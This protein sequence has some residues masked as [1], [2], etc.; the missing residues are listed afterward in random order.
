MQLP[1]YQVDAFTDHAL[2]GNPAAVMPLDAWLSDE[3]L[4]AIAGENNLSETAYIVANGPAYDLRWF[5]PTVEVDLCGHA[6]L[7]TAHVLF[8]HLDYPDPQIR[9]LTRS[10]ELRV[11][12]DG[13]GYRMDFPTPVLVE[14]A[15]SAELEAALGAP[16]LDAALPAN[17]PSMMVCRLESED[18]VAGLAPDFRALLA[19][20]PYSVIA[21][22]Q[23]SDRD[24][25]S[26]FFGPQVGVDEDPVTG[27][28]HCCL[29][30]YWA[31]RL[32]RER[33]TARQISARVGELVCELSGERVYLSGNA[34]TYL[35]GVVHRVD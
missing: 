21:T 15:V 18:T 27:S 30:A 17:N 20:T 11:T 5:T 32:Q 2:G 9:F 22:A 28:A 23:G 24:M 1:L 8:E 31:P 7:A 25:V 4:Q 19:A 13:S 12:R 3:L 34:V 35:T 6:T 10:G 16:V 26:R 33:L 29:T 14:A